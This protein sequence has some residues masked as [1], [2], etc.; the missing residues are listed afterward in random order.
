MRWGRSI[1]PDHEPEIVQCSMMI[2]SIVRCNI[3]TGSS[4]A[5]ASV[6]EIPMLFHNFSNRFALIIFL[7]LVTNTPAWS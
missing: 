4:P 5:G 7:F 6:A 3:H 2:Y 1:P